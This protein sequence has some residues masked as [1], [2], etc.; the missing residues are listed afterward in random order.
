[1]KP[2][3]GLTCNYGILG[4]GASSVSTPHMPQEFDN[5]SDNYI[6]AIERAGG[7][8]VII[9]IYKDEETIKDILD[10][11]DGVLLTG[12]SDV[13]SHHFGERPSAKLG[14]ISNSR[15]IQELFIAKYILNET[16]KPLMGICR[17][18]QLLNV[19]ANGTLIQDLQEV[20]YNKHNIDAYPRYLPSH[21]DIVEKGSFLSSV[22]ANEKIGVNSYHHQAVKDVAKGF[23]VTAK[24]EDNVIEA[25]EIENINERFVLG[26]QWHPEA[27]VDYSEHQA[28][29]K[30]FVSR[31]Q[32]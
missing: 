13:G 32:K 24:S 7:I 22:F 2:L 20:G 23:K 3:I 9:P 8:P 26:V 28:I 12:G 11:L 17:G 25:L 15:D 30:E 18:L 14:T 1:M 19:A 4:S 31:C 16:K 5:I 6:K 21:N 29:F 27:L 10:R